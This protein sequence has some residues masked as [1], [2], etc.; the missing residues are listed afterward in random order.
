MSRPKNRVV[1]LNGE[2]INVF[3]TM[4]DAELNGFMS[5]Y[6]Y[7]L[8]VGDHPTNRRES[9]RRELVKM[10][11]E[12]GTRDGRISPVVLMHARCSCGRVASIV[13]DRDYIFAPFM[14]HRCGRCLLDASFSPP[15]CVSE[16]PMADDDDDD[17]QFEDITDPLRVLSL[18]IET[19][20]FGSR[21]RGAYAIYANWTPA[22][23]EDIVWSEVSTVVA[24]ALTHDAAVAAA[25]QISKRH[26][27]PVFNRVVGEKSGVQL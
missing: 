26:N 19:G 27:C 20:V 13:V 11:T 2:P 9:L 22:A 7:R 4:T 15:Y 16:I 17:E 3:A 14:G 5:D 12:R 24:V 25:D 21:V 10:E 18:T 1:G 23:T 6:R 8:S